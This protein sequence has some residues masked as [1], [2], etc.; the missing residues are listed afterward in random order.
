MN[1]LFMFLLIMLFS[2]CTHKIQ[3]AESPELYEIIDVSEKRKVALQ[4]EVFVRGD[5]PQYD[6]WNRFEDY[7]LNRYIEAAFDRNPS[8]QDF[9]MRVQAAENYSKVIQSR[10]WPTLDAAFSYLYSRLSP[11]TQKLFPQLGE[12]VHLGS[13]NFHVNYELDFR[14]KNL[15]SYYLALKDVEIQRVL[16]LE[17][18]IN[19]SAWIASEYYCLQANHHKIHLME[20]LIANKL[21]QLFLISKR[22]AHRL[23][24]DIH[25]CAQEQELH[26]LQRALAGL[27]EEQEL[28]KTLLLTLMGENPALDFTVE[29]SWH[30][31]TTLFALPEKIGWELFARRPEVSVAFFQV[32]KAAESVGIA[33]SEFFPIVDLSSFLG[34][35]SFFLNRLLSMD[36]F[37]PVILPVIKLPLF[38]GGG[39]RA[40]FRAKKNL[41]EASVHQYNDVALKAVNDIVSKITQLSSVQERILYQREEKFC[42]KK[43]QDLVQGR[44]MQGI[45]PLMSFLGAQENFLRAKF[46]QVDLEQRKYISM[47]A[48]IQALGGGFYH[49]EGP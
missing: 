46:V 24:S 48:L 21:Q 34:F 44:Y 41:Y 30:A 22:K 23:D 3:L 7:Q 35:S 36:S 9:T 14:G 4:E 2:S 38:R 49:A 43:I 12:N 42:A 31:D 29:W 6:W 17:A 40:N 16:L 11:E 15:R 32:Q 47:I 39:L 33:F 27:Q 28:R 1:I 25:V 10:L 37:S 5:W 20:K 18:K 19:L 45:D 8:L 13:L 26:S